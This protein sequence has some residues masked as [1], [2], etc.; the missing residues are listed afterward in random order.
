MDKALI[1]IQISLD[2]IKRAAHD[3]FEYW[4]AR[5]LINVLGYKEW[6]KFESVIQ[7]AKESN[8]ISGQSSQDHFVSADKMVATGSGA[9]RRVDDVLLTRLACYLIAL[10]GDPRKPEISLS[11]LYFATQ[12]RK[13]ELLEQRENEN[14]R[15]DSRSKLKNTEKKIQKRKYKEQ[16]MREA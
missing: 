3:G 2:S 12:T 8:E 1:Q 15:L 10:N 11:Q 9:L 5:D 6:R 16:C 4:S 7:K 14:K 13:Q